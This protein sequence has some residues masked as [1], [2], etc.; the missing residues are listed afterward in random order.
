[1]KTKHVAFILAVT[2][3]LACSSAK[4]VVDPPAVDLASVG[5]LGLV[6]LKADNVKGDLDAAATQYFLQEVNA[7][8]RV[9]VLELGPGDQVLADI[10]KTA[11]DREAALALGQKHGLDAFFAGEVQVTKV[12][13][14]IDVMA[15][16]NGGLF[17]RATVDMAIKVRLVSCK[18]GATLWT[19]S[20]M[21]EGTI[22]SVGMDGG[23]PVV[24]ARDK[25]EALD[26]LLR[27]I[28]YQ[29]TWDFRPTRRRL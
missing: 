4:Y 22:G 15:P 9:P 29:L 8:Q 19:N 6:V 26:S 28:M 20:T 18:N 24:A 12:K 13:P 23:V 21:R 14:Q 10:G 7:A 11:F 2:A 5:T 16:L 3:A 1:M 25:N 27:E 17:A